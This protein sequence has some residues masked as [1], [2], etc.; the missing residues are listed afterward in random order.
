L[1]LLLHS[2]LYCWWYALSATATWNGWCWMCWHC[3]GKTNDITVQ[4]T[5]RIIGTAS[6]G[7]TCLATLQFFSL[8]WSCI[9]LAIT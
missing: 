7:L 9:L 6:E 8:D 4:V 2:L 5:A 1:I 3:N